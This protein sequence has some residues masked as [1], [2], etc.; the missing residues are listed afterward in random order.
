MRYGIWSLVPTAYGYE[1]LHI[2]DPQSL[3]NIPKEIENLDSL[4]GL[5][6]LWL[7]QNKISE[8]KV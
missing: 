5:E 8:L 4:T 7:A 2:L 3:A 6:Q 1:A